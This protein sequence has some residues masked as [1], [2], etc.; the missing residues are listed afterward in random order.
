MA[1]GPFVIALPRLF[2]L[3]GVAAAWLIAYVMERRGGSGLEKPLWWSLLIGLL[4]ARLGFVLTH[5]GDY[6]A[7]PWEALY[8]WQ[9]GYVPLL[10]AAAAI[11]VAGLF[12]LRRHCS[13]Q[14]LFP[15][16][17]AG[18]FVWGGLSYLNDALTAATD[19]PL[20]DLVL[21]DLSGRPVNVADFR[22]KP[23]VVNL[24]A[25]WCPPCRREMPIL[26][27]AQRA[28]PGVAFLFVNQAEGPETIRR[29]LSAESLQLDNILLDLGGRIPRDF[30]APGL[31]TT[32]F[33]NADGRLVDSHL[34]ELSR[35]G[36]GDYLRK[37]K[38]TD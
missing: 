18:L 1:F 11:L 6:R 37:L 35:A 10:G 36:L 32:L 25:T 21:E 5:L 12:V 28:E 23:V 7:Q 13:P 16:L 2:L 4:A 33:F 20:P 29:Y 24:W 34:G 26:A 15:P 17:L 9:G 27:D 3:L 30:N 14:R 38:R 8:L 31:P 22:G 19:K